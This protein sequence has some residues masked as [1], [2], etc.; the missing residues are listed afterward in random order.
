MKRKSSILKLPRPYF[1]YSQAALWYKNK[2]AYIQRYFWNEPQKDTEYTIFG[3]ELHERIATD[4]A[5][6][7]IR[8]PLLEE[9][10]EAEIGGVPVIGYIDAL[11]LDKLILKDY[12]SS[13]NEWTQIDVEKLVQLE[14][15]SLL[16]KKQRNVTIRD[17]SV[18]WLETGW[19]EKTT[20][21]GGTVITLS[22]TLELTGKRKEFKRTIFERDRKYAE[23]YLI[24]AM[25]QISKE[26]AYYENKS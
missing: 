1:S 23:E 7:D 17:T 10:V 16:L 25:E 6:K 9:K 13:K 18:V 12:K 3:R 5:F 21:Q 14:V 22:R 4:D 19:N 20:K 26:Y 11:D 15:Y 2:N 8:L 24:K